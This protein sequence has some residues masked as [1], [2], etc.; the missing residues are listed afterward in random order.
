MPDQPVWIGGKSV[1]TWGDWSWTDGAA[2]SY[3]NWADSQ[4]KKDDMGMGDEN[5]VAINNWGN[6]LGQWCF[7]HMPNILFQIIFIKV[8]CRIFSIT[9]TP[10]G[11]GIGLISIVN[12]LSFHSSVA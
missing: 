8:K 6:G 1:T 10:S 5:C 2:W 9:E 11:K 12:I 4:P 7:C 3:I